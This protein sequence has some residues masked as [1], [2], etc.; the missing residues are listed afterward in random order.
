M[1]ERHVRAFIAAVVAP[2]VAT[3]IAAALYVPADA[4]IRG[5]A[6]MGGWESVGRWIW[7]VW[8]YSLLFAVPVSLFAGLP[9]HTFL[10]HFGHAGL[11]A[12]LGAGTAA[13]VFTGLVIFAIGIGSNWIGLMALGALC[14][15]FTSLI[16]W[17]MRRPDRDAPNPVRSKP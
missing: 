15:F 7:I 16:A 8:L 2:I 12:Y 1:R 9:M 14:G 6:P 10:M 17:L 3:L 4:L 13:G 5:E 11:L